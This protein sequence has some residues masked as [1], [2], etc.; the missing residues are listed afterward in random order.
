MSVL[1]TEAN[2]LRTNTAVTVSYPEPDAA[3]VEA[4]RRRDPEAFKELV[5]RY[6]SR[7]L[8]LAQRITRNREDAEDVSQESFARA[9]LR[10]DT[11]RGD[12]RFSTWLT[13]I[14]I[15]QSLM[16]L[17]A[18]RSRELH[19]GVPA[20]TEKA[21]FCAELAD[22][23]PSPEQRYSREE[24]QR[25]LDSAMRELPITFREVVRLRE[26][27]ERSTKETARMMGLSI[28]AVKSRAARGQL[29]LRH[30]LTKYFRRSELASF[31]CRNSV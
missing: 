29:M 23:S 26:V 5:T 6:G 30:A 3:L 25:I 21:P 8:L 19:F 13:R 14:T 20:N 7:I 4:A 31:S 1:M 16:K 24:L 27:E 17:R 28:P 12:S 10:L 2:T 9:F 15:N 22:D 18:R 11:F